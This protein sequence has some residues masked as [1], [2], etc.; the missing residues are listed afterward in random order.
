MLFY[1]VLSV[2][3]LFACYHLYSD[4]KNKINTGNTFAEGFSGN[5]SCKDKIKGCLSKI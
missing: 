1:L 5:T 3:V 2:M 4:V